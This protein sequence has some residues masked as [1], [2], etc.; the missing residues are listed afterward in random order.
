MSSTN[1]FSNH[2]AKKIENTYHL[3]QPNQNGY[4]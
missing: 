3:T 2:V 4:V 1:K